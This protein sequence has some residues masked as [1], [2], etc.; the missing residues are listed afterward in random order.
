[1]P[2]KCL[3]LIYLSKKMLMQFLLQ[4]GLSEISMC[5]GGGSI[6]CISL[7]IPL[8]TPTLSKTS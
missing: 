4:S 5:E 7:S 6:L 3:P 1:M 2:T 8:D